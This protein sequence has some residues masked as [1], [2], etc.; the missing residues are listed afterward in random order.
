MKKVYFVAVCALFMAFAAACGFAGKSAGKGFGEV[1][2][3]QEADGSQETDIAQAGKGDGAVVI[4]YSNLVDEDSR[5]LTRELLQGAGVSQDRIALFFQ[6]VDQFADSIDA[7]ALTD[8]W[9]ESP[10]AQRRYDPYVLQ[11]QWA[12][13]HGDFPGYNCRL[14][15]MG[16][17]GGQLQADPMDG[18]PDPALYLDHETL[19]MD[20]AA[21]PDGDKTIFDAMF[22]SAPAAATRDVRAQAGALQKTW[23]DRGVRFAQNPRMSDISVV[24]FNQYAED[25]AELFIGHTGVL[26]T[27]A[28]GRLFFLE[29]LAFQEPYRLVEIPDREALSDYLTETYDVE[30]GQA[31]SVPFLMENDQLMD[32]YR[33]NP[34]KEIHRKQ[35]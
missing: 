12:A 22:S 19:A 15:V 7:E 31:G 5:K 17:F 30:W 14:T 26:L 29:K 16:L 24:F 6:H 2:P 20:P 3:S 33:P 10:A 35:G 34:L 11:D 25:D 28:D 21:L 9:E 1:E 32:G 13:G 18:D 23:A 8:S 27:A 4:R